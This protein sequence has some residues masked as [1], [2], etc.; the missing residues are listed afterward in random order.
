MIDADCQR[1]EICNSQEFSSTAAPQTW[2]KVYLDVVGSESP[3]DMQAAHDS[4]T[5]HFPA[6]FLRAV[7]ASSFVVLCQLQAI[8]RVLRQGV[9]PSSS[10]RPI[11]LGLEHQLLPHQKHELGHVKTPE[12]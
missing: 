8:N 12:N 7:S 4:M 3:W 11:D 9:R 2:F 6:R 10:S 5:Q 1:Y